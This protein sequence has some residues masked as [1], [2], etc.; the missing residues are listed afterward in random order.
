MTQRITLNLIG[1]VPIPVGRAVE[2][3]IFM[4]DVGILSSKIEPNCN[5]AKQCHEDSLH[6]GTLGELRATTGCQSLV[7]MFRQLLQPTLSASL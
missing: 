6:E 5:A 1:T 4:Q 3:V 7:D 2:V